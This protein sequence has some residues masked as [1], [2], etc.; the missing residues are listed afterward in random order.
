MTSPTF[1]R[2]LMAALPVTGLLA[3][4]ALFAVSPAAMAQP[5]ID[6]GPPP[7]EAHPPIHITRSATLAPIGYQPSQVRTAYGFPIIMPGADYPATDDGT[8][9]RIAIVDS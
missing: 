5:P 1:R 8:G 3:G 4:V 7:G 6:P 9:Q 2:A